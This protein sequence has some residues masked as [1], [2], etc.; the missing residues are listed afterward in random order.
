MSK[1]QKRIIVYC[2]PLVIIAIILI[3]GKVYMGR[4]QANAHLLAETGQSAIKMLGEYK[5][6]IEK[7]DVGGVMSCYDDNYSS[8]SDGMWVEQLRSE[9]DGVRVYEWGLDEAR[10][11][12]KSDVTQ[13]ISRYLNSISSVEEAKCKLDSVEEISSD[14]AATIRSILWVRGTRRGEAFETHALFRYWLVARGGIWT[15]QKQMLIH[16]ETV[17][18]DRHGFTDVTA[19]AGIDFMSHLNPV[20]DTPEWYPKKFQI[21]KYALGGVS[22]IDYDNDGWYDIFFGDGTRPRLYHNIGDGTF[23]DVTERSGLPREMIGMSVGIFADFNNDGY[24]DLFLGCGTGPNRLLRN[25]GNG[26]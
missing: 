20:W 25:N 5:G 12:N 9:K 4:V 7:L 8:D 1:R 10:P 19:E 6:G 13:Q 23:S 26:T 2:S 16:G 11:F 24:K 14:H 17:M 21:V 3:W 18:G 22:A 15:I